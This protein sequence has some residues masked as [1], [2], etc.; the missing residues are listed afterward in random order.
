MSKKY[1]LIA[2]INNRVDGHLL[3]YLLIIRVFSFVNEYYRLLLLLFTADN[4]PYDSVMN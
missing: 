2:N 1:F 3:T 4:V